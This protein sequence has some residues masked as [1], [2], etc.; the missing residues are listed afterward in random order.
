M[1]LVSPP[2]PCHMRGLHQ[3]DWT[4]EHSSGRL[5]R[6]V[7]SGEMLQQEKSGLAKDKS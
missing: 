5:E 6:A 3:Q 1:L 7:G 2:F 4:T